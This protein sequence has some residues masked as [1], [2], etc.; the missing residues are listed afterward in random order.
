VRV[1]SRSALA[2]SIAIVTAI[3]ASAALVRCGNNDESDRQEEDS[4]VSNLKEEAEILLDEL[5]VSP[6][7]DSLVRAL[8]VIERMQPGGDMS[9]EEVRTFREEKLA[10]LLDVL[11]HIDREL[12]SDFDFDAIPPLSIAPPPETGLPAGVD[13]RAIADP[14]MRARYWAAIRANQTRVAQ[15]QLQ[16]RLKRIEQD[17]LDVIET[18][19]RTTFSG[20][21]GDVQTL[22][23]L[24]DR[25]IESGVRRT[26]L[27]QLL[28]SSEPQSSY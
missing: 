4:Y 3:A 9:A 27:A 19:V 2:A 24:I 6:D 22:K 12:V 20:S 8:E 25:H 5:D 28:I 1:R 14:T 21:P 7:P 10:L 18:H 15:Y 16:Y 17:C 13:P 11:N 26:A 23:A